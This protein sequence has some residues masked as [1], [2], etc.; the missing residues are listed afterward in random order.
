MRH[1]ATAA[2]F[3]V[4]CS[5]LATAQPVYK[6]LSERIQ[7]RPDPTAPYSQL[8]LEDDIAFDMD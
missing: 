4:L 7:H 8:R 2:F 3:A 5:S 6:S 1:V